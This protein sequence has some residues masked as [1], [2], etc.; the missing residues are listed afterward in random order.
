MPSHQPRLHVI[1]PWPLNVY[2]NSTPKGCMIVDRLRKQRRPRVSQSVNARRRWRRK[3]CF[4]S[5]GEQ[6]IGEYQKE[7]HVWLPLEFSLVAKCKARFIKTK[8]QFSQVK[9]DIQFCGCKNFSLKQA[10]GLIGGSGPPDPPPGSATAKL[11]FCPPPS[12]YL[13]VDVFKCGPMQSSCHNQ[14]LLD[15]FSFRFLFLYS[16]FSSL[17]CMSFHSSSFSLCFSD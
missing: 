8:K 3:Y 11:W 6:I 5:R 15:V 1:I 2:L 13:H 7:I 14:Y 10:S 17:M 9:S 16:K 4:A 12:I